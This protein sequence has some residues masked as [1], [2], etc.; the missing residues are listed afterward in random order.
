MKSGCGAEILADSNTVNSDGNRSRLCS[1][2]YSGLSILFGIKDSDTLTPLNANIDQD[3]HY[4]LLIPQN[5]LAKLLKLDGQ[6]GFLSASSK[7]SLVHDVLGT[8]PLFFPSKI[9]RG[10]WSHVAYVVTKEPNRIICYING[11]HSG[12]IKDCY[13]ALPMLSMGG[14]PYSLHSFS[15][16]IIDARYWSHQRSGFQISEKFHKLLNLTPPELKIREGGPKS[17]LPS[18]LNSL[19]NQTIHSPY[20]DDGLIAWWTFDDGPLFNAVTDVTRNRF[21]SK[22]SNTLDFSLVTNSCFKLRYPLPTDLLAELPVEFTELILKYYSNNNSTQNLENSQEDSDI[23]MLSSNLLEESEK[24][25]KSISN[26]NTNNVLIINIF[27]RG[28]SRWKWIEAESI[29]CYEFDFNNMIVTTDTKNSNKKFISKANKRSASNKQRALP[30]SRESPSR[31]GTAS[32][33]NSK[34]KSSFILPKPPPLP[35]Y[36]FEERAFLQQ[37]RKKKSQNENMDSIDDDVDQSL[38]ISS[39]REQNFCLF[40]LRRTRLAKSGRDLQRTE[41][42][43]LGN[44]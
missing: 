14:S 43:K 17:D 26:N 25:D 16:I 41:P 1:S 28:I 39:F 44:Y 6:V 23:L 5:E 35:T 32:R 22:L 38:P 13:F 33:P 24:F 29:R 18:D 7:V 40:E 21:K 42:C 10:K 3:H 31:A 36:L 30:M 8:Q 19:P 9:P 27:L 37:E 15:G 4:D 20:E 11:K 34:E 2:M 12:S